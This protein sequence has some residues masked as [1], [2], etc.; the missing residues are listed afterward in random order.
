MIGKRLKYAQRYQEILTALLKN[1]FG[2]VV[3]DL[4]LLDFKR[5]AEADSAVYS[6]SIA[7][8]IRLVL[9][10]LGPTFVKLGQL[11]STRVD[12]ISENIIKELEKLQDHVAAI[13]FSDVEETIEKELGQPVKDIFLE[14]REEPIAS[15]SIGQVHYGKL[16][17]GQEVAIKVQRP[18]IEEKIDIDLQI[19]TNL[20]NLMEEKFEWAN[21]YRI[22]EIVEEVSRSIRL[23]LDYTVEAW[24]GEKISRQ[25]KDQPE[26]VIPSI[27]WEYTTKKILTMDFISGTKF[28]D[29]AKS[30]SEA[31]KKLIVKQFVECMFQQIFIDGFFH[32]DPHPGN[33]FV[34]PDKRIALIDFGMIGR[35]SPSMKNDLASV[36]IALKNR[37]IN[38]VIFLFLKLG[39]SSEPIDNDQIYA[40]IEVLI[41]MN[42]DIPL[43]QISLANLINNLMEISF[44]YRVRMPADLTILA[45]T[46]L[47]MEGILSHLDK[48]LSIIDMAQPF[49]EKLIRER[50]KPSKIMKETR[51]KLREIQTFLTQLMKSGSSITK[52]GKIHVEISVP[53][54]KNLSKKLDR[55]T[56]QLSFSIILLAFSIMMVGLMIGASISNVK[57]FLWNFPVVEVGGVVATLMFLWLLFSIL[58]HGKF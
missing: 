43:Q 40:D 56:N 1:G 53:E 37:D 33:L 3:K 39:Q 45:K 5:K 51:H 35:L 32:G 38:E 12:L 13:P 25:L 18:N 19:L 11:A 10:E 29:Y 54:V 57:T 22:S 41:E 36:I 42:M 7:E 46:L 15:A 14:V 23:E 31:G 20:T 24:N 58:K 2:F 49:G 27:H 50:L 55:V 9:E 52:D 8:R 21:N 17:N 28:R 48:D 16:P 47:T 34:L 44:K 26:Y 30:A 6:K 4:G